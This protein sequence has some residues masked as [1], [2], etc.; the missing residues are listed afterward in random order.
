M[1]H[2]VGKL[3]IEKKLELVKHLRGIER[4]IIM[5]LLNKSWNAGR[6]P[7]ELGNTTWSEDMQFVE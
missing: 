4:R 1:K 6:I 5:E 2:M 7:R 3:N